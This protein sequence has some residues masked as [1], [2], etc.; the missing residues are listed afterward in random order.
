MM[1]T[2]L[3]TVTVRSRLVSKVPSRAAMR[4]MSTL[5]EVG[6]VAGLT[7]G[8]LLERFTT[9]GGVGAEA[10]FA[11]LVERHGPMVLRVCRGILRDEHAA[12]DAFQATFLVLAQEWLA[13]GPRLSGP[14]AAQR[15]PARCHPHPSRRG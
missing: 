8:Q 9:R 15:H 14:L 13:L 1:L 3:L 12:E 11:A 10:A 2:E 7:D 6:L 4:H 5:F